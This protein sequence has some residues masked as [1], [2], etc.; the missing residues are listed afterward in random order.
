LFS[1]PSSQQLLQALAAR[2]EEACEGIPVRGQ[3]LGDSSRYK[4]SIVQA[5]RKQ[6]KFRNLQVRK[7]GLPP[8]KIQIHST[9]RASAT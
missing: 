7:G 4:T 6:I 9:S 1:S 8:L 3:T 5:S 2:F